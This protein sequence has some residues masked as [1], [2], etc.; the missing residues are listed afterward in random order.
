MSTT[1]NA[2]ELYLQK[3]L[4][5]KKEQKPARRFLKQQFHR[6]RIFTSELKHFVLQYSMVFSVEFL[7]RHGSADPG[8]ARA[9]PSPIPSHGWR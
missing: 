9:E 5:M 1:E 2:Q 7:P 3:V 4:W 8:E 6:T